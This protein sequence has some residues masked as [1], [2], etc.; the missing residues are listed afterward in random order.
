[1][2]LHSEGLVFTL[3]KTLV[4]TIGLVGNDD[5]LVEIVFQADPAMMKER[6]LRKYPQA[7]EQENALLQRAA[8][9]LQDYFDGHRRQFELTLDFSRLPAFTRKVLTTLSRVDY[10]RTLTYGELATLAGSPRAAR[11]VGRAMATNPFPIV[12]PCHRVVGGGGKL[13]GYSGGKGLATKQWLLDLEK[14]RIEQEG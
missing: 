5:R 3:L 13:T 6:I 11:A 1:M 2:T 14:Q 10:G 9:Q 4:G 12:V 8:G 7:R